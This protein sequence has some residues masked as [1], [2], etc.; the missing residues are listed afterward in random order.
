MSIESNIIN[1]SEIKNKIIIPIWPALL[2][3]IGFAITWTIFY[4]NM[5]IFNNMIW[6]DGIFRAQEMG[7]FFGIA[8]WVS[9]LTGIIFGRL[10][11]KYSRI[12]LMAIEIGMTGF[13]F[14]LNAFIPIGLGYTTFYCFL[15]L[16]IFRAVF[17]GGFYS[18][19]SSFVNDAVEE[20]SR[21]DFF[22]KFMAIS[23]VFQVIGLL[24][25]AWIFQNQFWREFLLALAAFHFIITGLV[26]LYAKEPLRGAMTKELKN[27]VSQGTAKYE[28]QLNKETAKKTLLSKTNKIVL[29]EGIFTSVIAAIPD[30]LIISYLQLPP[31]N[32]SPISSGLFMVFFGVPGAILGSIGFAK[33]SDKLSQKNINY[34]IYMITGSIMVIFI[35]YFLFFAFPFPELTPEQGNNFFYIFSFPIAWFFAIQIFIVRAVFGVYSI[36]Q[37]PILQKINLPEAQGTITSLNGL[38]E[39]IGAGA[40]PIIAGTLLVVFNGNFLITVVIT[41]AIGLFG[42]A[43]WLFATRTIKQDIATIESILAERAKEM[44]K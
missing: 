6:S 22:G 27:I 37:P 3:Q 33:L 4:I 18:T 43:C 21:S 44:M 38:L 32:I 29:L 28:Y 11:D 35:C 9:A 13:G 16:N 26:L 20:K 23:Q 40:G 24:L 30:F 2:I 17:G 7:L 19:L 14:F 41:S 12:R 36:N 10:A 5:V 25:S 31:H 34:R 39:S 1:E 15:G 42:A 8:G